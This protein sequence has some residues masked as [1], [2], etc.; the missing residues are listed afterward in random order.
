M[1]IY[2]NT[3]PINIKISNIKS[4]YTSMM[5]LIL[6]FSI[7]SKYNLS[8]LSLII[9]ICSCIHWICCFLRILILLSILLFSLLPISSIQWLL[10]TC[11]CFHA[12]NLCIRLCIWLLLLFSLISFPKKENYSP[13]SNHCKN[14]NNHSYN[15]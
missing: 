5:L 13:Y 6:I 3:I 9:G 2:L 8:C 10:S 7:S 1:L 4:N 15:L 14:S 12:S 11:C